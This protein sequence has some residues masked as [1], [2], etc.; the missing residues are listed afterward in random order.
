LRETRCRGLQQAVNGGNSQL[1]VI[2]NESSFGLDRS[3]HH[4]VTFTTLNM[5]VTRQSAM[6]NYCTQRDADARSPYQPW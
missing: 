3:E 5:F 4:A 2:Y 1:K 6:V